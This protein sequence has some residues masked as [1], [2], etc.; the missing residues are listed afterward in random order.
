MA[1]TL[2][3][4]PVPGNR[5]V[6]LKNS[7]F[8]S[9]TYRI[10][11]KGTYIL[12]ENIQFHPNASANY[13]PT[14]AQAATYP[15]TG[16]EAAYR[17]GFFAAI[18][19]EANDVV[20]D[21]NSKSL[22]QRRDHYVQ[23]RFLALIELNEQPF[24]PAQGPANF[25]NTIVT[26]RRVL[27]KNGTLGRSCHHG[28]H[29]NDVQDLTVRNVR[30]QDFEVAAIAI[31]GPRRVLI[32]RCIVQGNAQDVPVLGNYS[33]VRFIRSAVAALSASAVLNTRGTTLTRNQ[34]LA[35]IDSANAQVLALAG[36]GRALP[37]GNVFKNPSGNTDGPTY[38][39]LINKR[40]IAVNGF[41]NT[42]TDLRSDEAAHH[43][44]IQNTVVRNIK[45][46]P[47]E[48]VGIARSDMKATP[49]SGPFGS[50]LRIKDIWSNKTSRTYVGNVLSDAK[51]MLGKYGGGGSISS[52]VV[53]WAEG[54]AFPAG[55]RLLCNG[56]TMFH[57]HK[58]VFGIRCDGVRHLLIKDTTVDSIYNNGALGSALGGRYHGPRGGH[59]NQ[60][61]GT[62]YGGADA[63]G[64]SL[65]GCFDAKIQK[66]T[67]TNVIS[68]CASAT[69]IDG[70]GQSCRL[71]LNGNTVNMIVAAFERHTPYLLPNPTPVAMGID[72]KDAD[73][74][75]VHRQRVTN[76]RGPLTQ[77]VR[78]PNGTSAGKAI[79]FDSGK[80]ATGRSWYCVRA[81]KRM[82]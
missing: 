24:L 74:A 28:I 70:F 4:V 82:V 69:G 36:S 3:A 57:V 45:A 50:I 1:P 48:V 19:V 32:D 33:G 64:I 25:G 30:F 29:G 72:V 75:S 6:H 42:C 18:T 62:G 8:T 55:L 2:P 47:M 38:G 52:S 10:Q 21:L 68:R 76:I 7:D 46:T 31:N 43:V 78:L 60:N 41:Q 34:L 71:Q 20:I 17:L 11:Q 23:Q 12:D 54:G 14:T 61:K 81:A 59:K 53:E 49:Q 37:A 39:I 77:A 79:T 27:I 66:T 16:N 80:S 63:R 22:E 58:G 13:M 26:P 15:T 65:A 73:S 9:G 67:V 56:D 40:G 5:V 51:I 44:T 35:N